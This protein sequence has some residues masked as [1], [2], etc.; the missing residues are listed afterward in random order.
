MKWFFHIASTLLVVLY[1]ILAG[2]TEVD[3]Q[4]ANNDCIT[5]QPVIIPA[6]GTICINSSSIN[7]TSSNTTNA[8]NVVAVNE[9]WFSFV[10]AGPVNTITITPNGGTP[11]QQA[12]VT[13]SDAACG[14]G[15]FN[16][17]DASAT[18]GGTATANWA[19]AAGSAVNVSVAGILA[20]GTFE[21]CI[22][23]ETPPPTPGSNCGGATSSCDPSDFTLASTAGNFSSGISPP[24]FNI[25]GVPQIV[26][27]DVWFVFTVGQTGTL[28][29]TANLNGVAEFDWAVYN[30]TGGCPG[31]AVSCNYFFS[32]GNSGTIGLVPGGN[33]LTGE[34]SPPLNVVAGNTYA[35]MMD[36]YDNNGIGF[37]FTWGG[38]FQM[39]PT[40][41]FTITTPSACNSLTTTF[42]NNTVGASTYAW[43]FGNGQ[44]SALQNPPAQTYNTPGTYFVTLEATSAAGCIN[45]TSA[46]VEVF[47]DPTLNFTETDESCTGSCDGQIIVNPSGNGPFTYAWAGGGATNTLSTL[48]ANTYN[49]TVTDQSNGCT[50]TGSGIVAS[51][52]A[53]FDA[54]INIPVPPSPYCQLDAAVQLTSVDPGGI[55]TGTGVNATGLFTPANATIGINTITYTIPGACG[56][57]GTIDL[58]V[59]SELDATIATPPM[60]FC[61]ND[62][63]L[64]LTAAS[65]GGT[66]SGTGVDPTNGQFDPAT[67]AIGQNLVTYTSAGACPNADQVPFTVNPGGTPTIVA[68]SNGPFCISDAPMLLDPGAFVGGIWSG[69]G[70]DASGVFS[71]AIAGVGNHN[72]TYTLPAPCGGSD[73]WNAI[74][75]EVNFTHTITDPLC[76]GGSD[77]IIEFTSVN[78]GVPPYS[79]STDGGGNWSTTWPATGIS[80]GAVQLIVQDNFGCESLVSNDNIGE[81]TAII[82]QT[83][84]I[85][86]LCGQP[87][88]EATASALGGTVVLD[89]T[90]SW[91]DPAGQNTAIASGLLPN[92]AN[93]P[94]YTVTVTDDNNCTATATA[95]IGSVGGFTSEISDTT[96]VSCFGLCD[97]SSTVS[98][99]P[100]ITNP[101]VYTWTDPIGT[102]VGSSD[103]VT[104][105]CPDIYTVT[106]VDADNCIS[107]NTIEIFEPTLLTA[108]ISGAT[109]ICTGES[110]QLSANPSGGTPGYGY[111][112]S[113]M[114][115]DPAF[116]NSSAVM[117]TITGVSTS[118]YSVDV[119][120]QNGC[121]ASASF[122]VNVLPPLDLNVDPII[123][124]CPG[125][126]AMVSF[127]ATGGNGNYTFGWSIDGNAIAS[128][129]I[130]PAIQDQ[131]T[132]EIT[133]TDNCTQPTESETVTAHTI[134]GPALFPVA[135]PDTLCAPQLVE[136][137]VFPDPTI[138]VTN[139]QWEFNDQ[140]STHLEVTGPDSITA[141]HTYTQAG[142]YQPNLHVTTIDGCLYPYPLS[143]LINPPPIAGMIR[144]PGDSIPVDFLDP[145]IIF[146]ELNIGA[147]SHWIHF[148]DGDSTNLSPVEHIY[149]D[150]GLYETMMIAFNDD[151]C[152]DTAFGEVHV[153]PH[154]AFWVPTAFTPN[155]DG[156]N[157]VLK[158][159]AYGLTSIRM[160]I[161]N[162]WGELMR[163]FDDIDD[164][165]DGTHHNS[166]CPNGSYS[167]SAFTRDVRGIEHKYMGSVILIGAE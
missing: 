133:V 131:L 165:W 29:F 162:R 164:V 74:V 25:G 37:D 78:G 138:I 132:F 145:E 139:Y 153:I 18:A 65:T 53:T 150:S 64:Q 143:I 11:L 19:Y 2:T 24:C 141:S 85:S 137:S 152:V 51:G 97:G 62:P 69:P 99:T 59:L 104:G 126:G 50:A 146:E 161:H 28:E 71:P 151:G 140:H 127:S 46:S 160:E 17:C 86:S 109:T 110:V 136:F 135:Q 108:T 13:I 10:A 38:T 47:P 75:N 119:L 72:I 118:D 42:T 91:D 73:T 61:Q 58:E 116:F 54:T 60:T 155:G 34:F 35:I 122:M 102:I 7:A 66:W 40:A 82:P 26:Q 107:T 67:A 9:V 142:F 12:V 121:S 134:P 156:M 70:I 88:G 3:A 52:G 15:T 106:I 90:Y 4:P 68:P 48:C 89:Y 105:L 27:N 16:M 14:G 55:Y 8:C 20:D 41:D 45:I 129:E 87:N 113:V 130:T 98:V 149:Q 1:A 30:I 44:T 33:P 114:P 76:N 23:S 120:D 128:P 112:W 124:V 32:G 31:V 79:Y 166:R 81:P 159:E 158:A 94:V 163:V 77:G 84:V 22:T 92:D 5:A 101:A 100:G 96:D 80:G 39:A 157:E 36:N 43:D 144:F 83:S 63:A 117:Q 147:T 111:D 57:V 56:D 21:I 93:F 154:Y 6:G 49:V 167:Y 123:P 115:A 95:I 148:G 103:I 125:T